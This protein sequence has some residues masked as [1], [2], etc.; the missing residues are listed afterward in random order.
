MRC[1][2]EKCLASVTGEMIAPVYF[3]SHV[4]N[5]KS[6][7]ALSCLKVDPPGAGKSGGGRE[8]GGVI[9]TRNASGKRETKM[10]LRKKRAARPILMGEI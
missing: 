9:K 7:I 4:N 3:G 10:G 2:E 6:P 5:N 1:S 8:G